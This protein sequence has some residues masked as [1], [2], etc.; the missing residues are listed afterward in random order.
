M[1]GHVGQSAGTG[2][3]CSNKSSSTSPW[4]DSSFRNLTILRQLTLAFP[5]D[6]AVTAKTM[7]IRDGN[8]VTCSGTAQDN[9]ALLADVEPVAHRGRR[10]RRQAGADSRQIAHAI[11]VRHPLR[12]RRRQ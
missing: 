3:A 2:R 6:G 7:E 12:Q 9:G 1:V 4:F 11:H 8:T 5:E 10:D